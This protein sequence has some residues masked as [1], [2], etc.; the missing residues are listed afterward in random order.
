MNRRKFLNSLLAIPVAGLACLSLFKKKEYIKPV[1]M[2]SVFKESPMF[3]GA[4]IGQRDYFVVHYLTSTK[5]VIEYSDVKDLKYFVTD[6]S[7]WPYRGEKN[8]L[9]K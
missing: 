1:M 8:G 3:I 4:D 2:D 5:G 9:R 7:S 6:G